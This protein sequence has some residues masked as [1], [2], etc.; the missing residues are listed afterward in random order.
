MRR[1]ERAER[2]ALLGIAGATVATGALQVAAPRTVLQPLR[3][4][5]EAATRHFFGTVG[6]FMVV[7]GG[8]LGTT[9]LRRRPDADVVLFTAAQK[10]GAAGAVGLAVRRGVLAP[11]AAGVAGFDALSGA[12][13]LDYWRRV[14]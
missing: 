11:G 1:R 10:L 4:G 5:D 13:A 9:L 12:L 6:M 8:L 7:V 3:G 14:R 2:R